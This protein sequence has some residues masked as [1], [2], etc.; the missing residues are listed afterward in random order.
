MKPKKRNKLNIVSNTIRHLTGIKL[1]RVV[2][3]KPKIC[4]GAGDNKTSCDDQSIGVVCIFTDTRNCP[5][6]NT[7]D[8]GFSFLCGGGA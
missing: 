4:T 8:C 3:G 6:P 1:V 2:G 5:N 7:T